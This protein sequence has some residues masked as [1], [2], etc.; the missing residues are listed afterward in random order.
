MTVRYIRAVTERYKSL[1]YPPYRWFRAE[2]PP[3]WQRLAK[4]LAAAR[5][6]MLSTSGAYALGQMAYHY[7]DDTSI[8]AIP[9]S[10]PDAALRFSH[11]TEN[12]L[13]D[14]RRDPG[15]LFPLRTLRVL[16]EER[17]IGEI[18]DAVLSC[19]G[20]IY[21][22]R[23]V[24]DELAPA[25]LQQFR[26]QQVDAVLLVPMCPVCHQSACIIAR[27]LEAHGIPTTCLGSALDILESGRPPRATFVDYPLGHTAGKPFDPA[28]QRDVV[29]AAL[30]G[31][32]TVTQP[33]EIRILPHRWDETGEWK[34]EAG[35][36]QG[37][38]TRRPRDETPQF[39][40]AADRDAALASGGLPV[41]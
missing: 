1:G 13:L 41:R 39:Q 38:D 24:R 16:S 31:L 35:R 30:A 10:T 6:G 3:P 8:R 14:A 27:H 18:P 29:C 15:C 26:V 34:K 40:Y 23:R 2:D 25:L 9:S 7:R 11:V 28:D 17:V 33:G 32:E 19:M 37:A 5:I 22:Q 21:S 36:T 20:G 4:P 12:F